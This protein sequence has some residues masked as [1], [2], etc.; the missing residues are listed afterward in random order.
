VMV[1][2]FLRSVFEALDRHAA[3]IDIVGISEVSMS[4]TTETKRLPQ[5]LLADLEKLA[6]V[7]CDDQQAIICLVGEDIHGRPGIAAN[8]FNA[9]AE[10]GVNIRMISQG[11]S[12]INISFVIKESD[13][14]RCVQ[15][16]HAH[17]FG[18]FAKTND[19]AKA[20][21]RGSARR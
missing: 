16:L 9:V 12:E 2:G 4:F 1:H 20:A 6:E 21:K 14:P 15:H 7:T 5:T 3:S 13:V 10:S 17:Y 18:G 19:K 8:V 11:A